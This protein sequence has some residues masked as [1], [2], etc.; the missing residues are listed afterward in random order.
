MLGDLATSPSLALQRRTK[1]RRRRLIDV[2]VVPTYSIELSNF[3]SKG[4]RPSI[5]GPA[6][7]AL[8]YQGRATRTR[9]RRLSHHSRALGAQS[10]GVRKARVP[11]LSDHS[12]ARVH[13]SRAPASPPWGTGGTG[14]DRAQDL[15]A[16]GGRRLSAQ[17]SPPESSVT[18]PPASESP[19]RA[20]QRRAGAC[21]RA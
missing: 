18:P 2:P 1:S 8:V 13:R 21:Q 9:D 12:T 17:W 16:P 3:P 4:Q 15:A 11:T 10:A 14:A 5:E 20:R 6:L 19:R 7:R